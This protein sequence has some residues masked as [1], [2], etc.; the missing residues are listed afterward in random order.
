MYYTEL[1]PRTMEKVYVPR[2][3]REKEMQRALMQYFMPQYRAKAR[4]AL[5]KAHRDDLIGFGKNCL[6]PPEREKVET[7]PKKGEGKRPQKALQ[8]SSRSAGAREK[9]GSSRGRKR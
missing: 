3:R 4:E 6:V 1:D 2:D 8:R 5:R 9:S 7:Q